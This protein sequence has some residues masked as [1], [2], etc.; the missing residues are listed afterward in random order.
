MKAFKHLKKVTDNSYPAALFQLGIMYHCGY[1]VEK[2]MEQGEK[3]F[4]S[5]I[6]IDR[7]YMGRIANLYHTHD[8]MQDFDKA[9][10]WYTILEKILDEDLLESGKARIKT[11]IQIDMG[12]LYEFGNGVKQNYQ[13]AFDCYKKLA[14]DNIAAGL[15]RLALTY[16]YGNGVPIDYKE[17]F[18]LFEKQEYGRLSN[19]NLPY[20][21]YYMG[22][23]T[24]ESQKT[25]YTA[26]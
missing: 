6:K 2:N 13:K 15:H 23:D 1:G 18:N 7:D 3:C 5:L 12:L 22:L 11:Q 21:H 14:D 20:V 19:G 4:D 26:R 16:Y 10:K 25:S 8:E 9:L 24:N 17:A